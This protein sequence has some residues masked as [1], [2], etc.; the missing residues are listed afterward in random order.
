[1]A[2][3]SF[4]RQRRTSFLLWSIHEVSQHFK[5]LY[6]IQLQRTHLSEIFIEKLF[7][8]FLKIELKEKNFPVRES[9]RDI[10]DESLNS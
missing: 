1:M 4:R 10:V 7:Q 3:F 2:R 9:N 5:F 6:L 8:F